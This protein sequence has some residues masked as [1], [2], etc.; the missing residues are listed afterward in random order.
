MKWY[1]FLDQE[2]K[3]RYGRDLA[4]DQT[5]QPLQGDPFANLRDHGRRVR[6]RQL[7]APHNV[8]HY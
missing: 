8:S 4:A 3:I 2:E 7:L 6:V 1:R 5:I